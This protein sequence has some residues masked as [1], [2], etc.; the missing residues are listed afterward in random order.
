MKNIAQKLLI[1]TMLILTVV[2]LEYLF[3]FPMLHY[4]GYRIIGAT[5]IRRKELALLL[6]LV[7][8]FISDIVIGLYE[9]CINVRVYGAFVLI[10]IMVFIKK[11]VSVLTVTASSLSASIIF[12]L[13]SNFAVWAEGAWYPK[14]FNGLMQCY[15]MAIPFFKY[16]ILGTLAFTSVFFITYYPN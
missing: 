8:L 11:K 7:V 6:P 12:F 4:C 2:I 16:E 9:S 14:S 15:T 3:L 10:D 1:L 5:H 13:V